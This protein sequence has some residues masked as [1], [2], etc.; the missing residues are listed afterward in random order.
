MHFRRRFRRR[1]VLGEHRCGQLHEN[2]RADDERVRRRR[3]RLHRALRRVC[4]LL[5]FPRRRDDERVRDVIG[6]IFGRPT[7]LTLLLHLCRRRVVS[8]PS[9]SSSHS[10]RRVRRGRRRRR[11]ARVVVTETT[12]VVVVRHVAPRDVGARPRVRIRTGRRPSQC[13]R[14]RALARTPSGRVVG[15]TFSR[16]DWRDAPRDL[17]TRERVREKLCR[18]RGK[19]QGERRNHRRRQ[20][21]LHRAADQISRAAHEDEGL[22][23]ARGRRRGGGQGVRGEEIGGVKRGTSIAPTRRRVDARARAETRDLVDRL[24]RAQPDRRVGV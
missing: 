17:E 13:G 8:A 20:A 9:R 12:A 18:R 5:R 3:R 7:T 21:R 11:R 2:S 4:A 22:E 1:A 23:A 16:D 15:R 19:A 10:C 14:G 24:E 6:R